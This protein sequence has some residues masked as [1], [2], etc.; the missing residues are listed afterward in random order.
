MT[1][2]LIHI[3]NI[4]K[5]INKVFEIHNLNLSC[6]S[7]VERWFILAQ[8]QRGYQYDHIKEDIEFN[9]KL[10]EFY[11]LLNELQEETEQLILLYDSAIYEEVTEAFNT[12]SSYLNP[13][14]WNPGTIPEAGRP[15]P[16]QKPATELYKFLYPEHLRVK[17][18]VYEI[19]IEVFDLMVFPITNQKGN[20][21]ED[22]QDKIPVIKAMIR[23][24]LKG[25]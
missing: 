24:G 12:L 1:K 20:P 25:N 18:R 4:K 23:R 14:N 2:M 8:T 21:I 13:A 9:K 22:I 6:P 3:S 17:N 7:E 15:S 10:K 5:K 16:F 11:K 19:I